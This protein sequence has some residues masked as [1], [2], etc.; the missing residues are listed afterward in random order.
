MGGMLSQAPTAETVNV[1]S[2][3]GCRKCRTAQLAAGPAGHADG[4]DAH[5]AGGRKPATTAVSSCCE[6]PGLDRCPNM[7]RA[8]TP[9]QRG[10]SN[11][12]CL[13]C[14][15]LHFLSRLLM[16]AARGSYATAACLTCRQSA[17]RSAP[18]WAALQPGTATRAAASCCSGDACPRPCCCTAD[19]SGC[20]QGSGG[21]CKAA[22]QGSCYKE[23]K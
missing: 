7:C 12:A 9:C 21:V 23:Q 13:S 14:T 16:L 11:C 1:F 3:C 17:A 19:A 20:C 4:R 18:A 5:A 8:Q 15:S 2:G 6:P 22:S 10:R